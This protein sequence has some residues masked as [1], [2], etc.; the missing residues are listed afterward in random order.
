MTTVVV[1]EAEAAGPATAMP[2]KAR[3]VYVRSISP[4]T[5]PRRA[6][7]RWRTSHIRSIRSNG[8]PD[9]IETSPDVGAGRLPAQSSAEVLGTLDSM[10]GFAVL[11]GDVLEE[12]AAAA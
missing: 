8:L 1:V 10:G 11:T 2:A 9:A 7:A 6:G 3:P 12:C 4:Q 5:A